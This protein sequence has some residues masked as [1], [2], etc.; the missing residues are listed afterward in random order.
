V[1]EAFRGVVVVIISR[2]GILGT[3]GKGW[4]VRGWCWDVLGIVE[5]CWRAEVLG[6]LA[7]HIPD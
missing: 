4:A 7:L 5:K 1:P 3:V 6:I 2:E